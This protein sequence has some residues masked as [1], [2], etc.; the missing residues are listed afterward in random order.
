MNPGRAGRPPAQ[1]E[2]DPGVTQDRD[3]FLRAAA[4]TRPP[5][6]STANV[7]AHVS[8]TR[9]E[10]DGLDLIRETCD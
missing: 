9:L 7:E 2:D 1:R 5:E 3:V 4:E 6:R 8:L 10:G